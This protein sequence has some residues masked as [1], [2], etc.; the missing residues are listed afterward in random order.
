MDNDKLKILIV[1]D[2]EYIRTMYAELFAKEGFEVEEAVDGLEGLEKITKSVPD[3]VFTGI[4]MPRMDGFGLIDS[5]KKNV[6]TANIPIFMSSHMG[7]KEDEDKARE[8]GVKEFFVVG[9]VSPRQ[10]VERVKMTFKGSSRYL[11]N[12]DPRSLDA[13]KLAADINLNNRNYFCSKCGA[14]LVLS[15]EILDASNQE[16]KTRF[17]CP[18]CGR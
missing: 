7:R 12:F 6:A 5:L 4:I 10:V 16:F 17:I 2:E 15:L 14:S 8:V 1:D 18:T 3:I 13:A 11:L 9:M